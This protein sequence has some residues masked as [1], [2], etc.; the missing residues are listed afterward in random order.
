MNDDDNITFTQSFLKFYL[1]VSS[2]NHKKDHFI[3]LVIFLS[4]YTC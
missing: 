2:F 4:S 3:V 1:S